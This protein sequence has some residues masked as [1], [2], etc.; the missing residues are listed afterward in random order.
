MVTNWDDSPPAVRAS[1]RNERG[2]LL[3]EI[4]DLDRRI[5]KLNDELERT[6]DT[7]QFVRR[8]HTARERRNELAAQLK[9][10]DLK[11]G[12]RAELQ[13][14]PATAA[15]KAK[16][17]RA[18]VTWEKALTALRKATGDALAASAAYA[19]ASGESD[20]GRF[21][22]RHLTKPAFAYRAHQELA[23]SGLRFEKHSPSNFCGSLVDKWNCKE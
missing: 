9:A 7:P 19:S 2:A 4:A 3:T 15:A 8:I 20:P 12:A 21:P 10:F 6:G 23:Q 14:S 17:N 1:D 11:L 22:H 5:A 13:E 18:V 16:F